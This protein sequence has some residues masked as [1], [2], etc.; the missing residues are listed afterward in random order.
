MAEALSLE[1]PSKWPPWRRTFTTPSWGGKASTC[2]GTAAQSCHAGHL[3]RV[4]QRNVRGH[5]NSKDHRMHNAAKREGVCSLGASKLELRYKCYFYDPCGTGA[6][7]GWSPF[8]L[9]PTL[10]ITHGHGGEGINM[11]WDSSTELSC[12]PLGPSFT[13]K[14]ARAHQ[15]QRSQDAQRRKKRRCVQ[16]RCIKVY[17][18]YIVRINSI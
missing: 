5:I 12:R 9:W 16:L 1:F 13:K 6:R 8:S 18:M 15:Q 4:S 7:F 3:G 11:P 17:I 2:H 10:Y 14:C